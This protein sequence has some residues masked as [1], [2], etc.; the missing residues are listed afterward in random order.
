[1]KRILNLLVLLTAMT[2]STFAAGNVSLS[3]SDMQFDWGGWGG[4]ADATENSITFPNWATNYW[5]VNNLSTD[6]YTRIDIKF[7]QSVNYHRISVKAVYEGY[8]GAD[9]D[10]NI[11][12][13]EVTYGA[14][15]HSLEFASGKK[16][17]K[18]I[19][20]QG[21]WEGLNKVNGEDVSA[22]IYFESITIVGSGGSGGTDELTTYEDVALSVADMQLPW[23]GAKDADEKSCSFGDVWSENYWTVGNLSTDVYTRVDMTFAQPVNYYKVRVK[24]V[25][26]DNSETN[27]PQGK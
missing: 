12:S 26:S 23:D 17:T 13:S 16:L 22:K 4:S 5:A 18:I 11:T 19:M 15:S 9:D 27:R 20:M 6:E 1:M 25:Y 3:V 2:S 10:P 14:T 7:A 8:T 24:A 21:D